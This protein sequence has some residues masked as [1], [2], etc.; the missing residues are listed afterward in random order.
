MKKWKSAL[1]FLLILSMVFSM[2][3]LQG[4]VVQAEEMERYEEGNAYAPVES[5]D[6][7]LSEGAPAAAEAE[8]E[9]G[10][11]ATEQTAPAESHEADAPDAANSEERALTPENDPKEPSSEAAPDAS[12]NEPGP[13]ETPSELRAPMRAP[14]R[15]LFDELKA[16]V[17]AAES[18]AEIALRPGEYIFTETLII[19]KPLTFN[20]T[21]EV[22]FKRADAFGN[23]M[24]R[25]EPAG[26]LTLNKAEGSLI[27]DGENRAISL[28]PSRRNGSFIYT[29]GALVIN[30]VHFVNDTDAARHSNIAPIYGDGAAAKVVFND[31]EISGTNY[32]ATVGSN[33]WYSSGGFYMNNGAALVM[34]G[35]SIRENKISWFNYGSWTGFWT[36]TLSAGAVV[37]TNGSTFVMNGGS[38]AE[39]KSYTGGVIVGSLNIYG[40]ERDASDPAQI[41]DEPISTFEMNGG[42]V[43]ENVGCWSAGGVELFASARGTMNGGLISGNFGYA[44]GGVLAMDYYLQGGLGEP[45]TRAKVSIEEWEQKYP[46]SFIMYGGEIA[47]NF[48]LT[49]GGGINASSNQVRLYGGTIAGNK[50]RDQGGG[51]YVTGVPY[52]LHV[53]NAFVSENKATGSLPSTFIDYDGV[54]HTLTSQSGGGV[55]FCPTGDAEFYAENGAVIVGNTADYAGDDFHNEAKAK[56]FYTVTLPTRFN[57]GALVRYF[58][59]GAA[60]RY[61]EGKSSE[62]TQLRDITD[63]LSLHAAVD[64]DGIALSRAV[65]KLFITGNSASKGGGIGSNGSVV[66]GKKPFEDNPLKDV[67][68]VKKWEEGTTPEEVTVEL[69]IAFDGLD[70]LV[71]RVT[72]NKENDFHDMVAGLPATVNGQPIETLLYAA[73]L[74]AEDY[75]VTIGKI[76]KIA[77]GSSEGAGN[78]QVPR[79][80]F[81]VVLTNKKITPPVPDEPATKDLAVSK[82]WKGIASDAAPEIKVWL[83]K[84][85]EKTERFLVLNTK[86]GW[87][88]SF[89]R[90]PV[91]DAADQPENVYTVLEEG[92]KEGIL[93]LSEQEFRVRYN[94]GHIV[95]ELVP[96]KPN[97]PTPKTPNSPKTGEDFSIGWYAG[98]AVTAAWIGMSI[99]RKKKESR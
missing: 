13:S 72:L 49:C 24:I 76:E 23:T 5:T 31:G 97:E 37:A 29:Q 62:I 95:N 6:S 47:N 32:Q 53:E 4:A 22:V 57:G 78:E 10:E 87:K 90:L 91:S 2:T 27:F 69:R 61:E 94:G 52:K 63:E 58:E 21:G 99:S 26:E 11:K 51:V 96:V 38:I 75:E 67:E 89:D 12:A 84:N 15:S 41:G 54:S 79:A 55:W 28:T 59:D 34:N 17:A 48:A 25:I 56:S 93:R 35:G 16:A 30:G 33:N 98:A 50:A 36:N 9:S 74:K 64:S 66:F 86:N 85:G 45:Q 14:G 71:G 77:D 7:T 80:L 73:E 68:I 44:G 19:D 82:E 20:S 1:S 60:M 3:V 92:E 88:G 46:A 8:V 70:Y 40:I 43:T 81:Q 39:N 42:E 65:S 83:V 18:G